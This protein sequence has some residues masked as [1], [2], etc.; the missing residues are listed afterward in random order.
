LS[1][2]YNGHSKRGKESRKGRNIVKLK[3]LTNQSL[4]ASYISSLP[5]SAI[6]F[7]ATK[8]LKN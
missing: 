3:K 1:R 2:N 7:P 6:A 8:K 5:N 4:E